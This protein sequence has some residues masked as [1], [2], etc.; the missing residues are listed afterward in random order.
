[1]TEQNPLDS[2][3]AYLD[4]LTGK[5][6]ETAASYLAE[7]FV[8]EGLIRQYKSADEFLLARVLLLLLGV[9]AGML[10]IWPKTGSTIVLR[11]A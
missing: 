2:V 1:M 3:V 6:F 4:A 9:E 5:D 10:S 11:R 7:D 8:F